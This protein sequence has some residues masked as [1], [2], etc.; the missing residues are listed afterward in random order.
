[1]DVPHRY[2]LWVEAVREW[3]DRPGPSFPRAE[4]SRLIG[5][6]FEA[7]HVGW[8]WR[9]PDAS[10]GFEQ[11]REVDGLSLV[12]P[13]VVD[14]ILHLQSTHPLLVWFA[15]SHDPLAMSIERIPRGVVSAS[16]YGAL[17]DLMRPAGLQQQLSIPYRLGD[18]HYRAFVMGRGGRDFTD[19]EL[20]LARRVQPLLAL[21]ERQVS[22]TRHRRRTAAAAAGL[23]GRETAVLQLLSE[24]GTADAIARRLGISPRTVHNHLANIYR[25]LDVTDRMRA[26]LIAQALGLI[27]TPQP[28]LTRTDTESRPE[29]RLVAG[30]AS[31]AVVTTRGFTYRPP[32][33][34]H[35]PTAT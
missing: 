19:E 29:V 8:N 10:F 14:W 2:A 28:N 12:D 3:C 33:A 18:T 21:L 13:A 15:S 22:V 6:S 7:A 1:M 27:D 34:E 35:R 9:D 11:D 25:K 17:R 26:V 24:G 32:R 23:T 5:E 30:L 4:V 16:E 20:D 31:G